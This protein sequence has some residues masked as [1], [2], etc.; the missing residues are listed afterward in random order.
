MLLVLCSEESWKA[1]VLWKE[2][3]DNRVRKRR[4]LQHE[5]GPGD[6][7]FSTDVLNRK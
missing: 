6:C 4:P 7:A 1:L 5:R 2:M 3:D